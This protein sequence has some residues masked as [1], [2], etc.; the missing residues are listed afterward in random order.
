M[1][2]RRSAVERILAADLITPAQMPSLA[3]R[4]CETWIKARLFRLEDKAARELWAM[5]RAAF[6][7]MQEAAYTVEDY[8]GGVSKAMREPLVAEWRA[9]LMRLGQDAALHGA[10]TALTAYY[11][12]YYGRAWLLDMVTRPDVPVQAPRPQDAMRRILEQ[13]GEG[14]DD[15]VYNLLGKEWRSTYMLEIDDLVVRVTRQLNL[16][17][18]EGEGMRPIMRRVS[19]A[20]GTD[21]KPVLI[22]DRRRGAVGSAERAQYRANFNRVQ[23]ITR[24]AVQTASNQGSARIYNDN[25]ALLAGYRHLTARDERVCSQ[26]AALDGYLYPV[27]EWNVPPGNTHPNCRCTIIPELREDY[28][29]LYLSEPPRETFNEWAAL[30]GVDYLLGAFMGVVV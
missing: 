6:R 22:T 4:T 13:G 25:A 30:L 19:S 5:Y 17:I 21:T 26:C 12:G 27:G 14:F 29:D 23:V 16:G 7:D 8:A 15:L 2:M 10:Q 24:T 18:R 9:R 3:G 1:A 28:A 11:A 20:M